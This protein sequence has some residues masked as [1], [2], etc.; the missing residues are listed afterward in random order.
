[1]QF[2]EGTDTQVIPPV[3]GLQIDYEKYIVYNNGEEILLP[4]RV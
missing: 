4:K 2:Y 3:N 1:M